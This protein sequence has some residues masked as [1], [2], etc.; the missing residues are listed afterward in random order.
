[1]NT[2]KYKK[3]IDD[4]IKAKI[5]V[6][7]FEYRYLK[8]FKYDSLLDTPE[9]EILNELFLDVDAYCGDPTLRR[10]VDL[11]EAQLRQK[12]ENALFALNNLK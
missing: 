1:M 2:D 3:L 12:A 8:T 7:D 9:Y 11:D 6:D 4:F 10:E 5:T